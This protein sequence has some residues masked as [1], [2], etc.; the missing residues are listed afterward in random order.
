MAAVIF[1]ISC[2]Q[3]GLIACPR[4]LLSLLQPLCIVHVGSQAKNKMIGLSAKAQP[5]LEGE[6]ASPLDRRTK[7]A[8]GVS[9]SEVNRAAASAS[10]GSFLS[11]S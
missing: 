7:A 10:D 11:M 2:V 3:T 5:S 9:H 1:L 8:G 4:A 6:E